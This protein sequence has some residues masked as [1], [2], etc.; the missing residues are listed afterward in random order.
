MQRTAFNVQLVTLYT[1]TLLQQAVLGGFVTLE[2]HFVHHSHHSYLASCS[3]KV[4]R[5]VYYAFV[6]V[7]ALI[8]LIQNTIKLSVRPVDL[9]FKDR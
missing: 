4:T 7:V 6:S 9:V 8:T 3:C 5:L 1:V 2:A